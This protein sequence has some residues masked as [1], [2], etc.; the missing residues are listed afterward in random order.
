MRIRT[1]L[2]LL[3][4]SIMALVLLAFA[5][6]IY[7]SYADY[8]EEEYY[9][10]LRQ[11]ALTKLHLLLDARVSARTLRVIYA[12]TPNAL[13]QEEV[14]VYKLPFHLLYHDDRTGD[15]VK[16]TTNLLK[17]I[18]QQGEI[19][20]MQR[21]HQV[22]GFRYQHQ[23]QLYIVTA[24]AYDEYGLSKL[25]NL[26]TTL[27]L[28]YLGSLLVIALL[29]R[30]LARQALNPMADVVRQ[31]GDIT[32]TSLHRRVPE[33]DGH[34]EI[35]E[36]AVTFNQMLDRLEQSFV[37]QQQFVSN[38]AHET[39]TPLAAIIAELDLTRTRPRSAE[40]YEQAIDR[41]LTDARR[42]TR[43]TAGLLD[44]AKANYDPSEITFR[45]VRLDELLVD[46]RS[47][48]LKGYPDWIIDIRFDQ[49]SENDH[50][51]TVSG[52]EYLLSVALTNLI[53]N[54]GKF[55]ADH[56][57][58]V[59]I[60]FHDPHCL[61][62]ISDRGIGISSTDLPRIFE[63]F[64]RGRNARIADGNGIGLALTR[65]IVS[66]HGGTIRVQSM[67]GEGTTITVELPHV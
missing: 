6:T 26:R 25:D 65:R 30:L 7:V 55:S 21:G 14:A 64:Y 22:V 5:L 44:L 46:V 31:V 24:A 1:R 28:T 3:F 57:A 67:L 45:P 50:Y 49:E 52:N 10:R 12:N 48:L 9:K 63:P 60:A 36:L 17:Q 43:L 20:F 42:L 19:R 66:L 53:E 18:E 37:S 39:R 33:G 62:R 61:L 59:T 34:D 29:S 2:S 32:A 58:V 11:Q 47:G 15:F 40:A 51:L 35:A 56:H 27:I 16:E 54:A 4:T 8:R 38:V 41:T 13:F 23:G